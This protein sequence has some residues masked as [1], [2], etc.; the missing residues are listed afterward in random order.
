M[1][2]GATPTKIP[3]ELSD[4]GILPCLDTQKMEYSICFSRFEKA[5]AGTALPQ[6]VHWQL[7]QRRNGGAF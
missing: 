3:H 5:V 2:K 6:E 7:Q 1:L 4:F